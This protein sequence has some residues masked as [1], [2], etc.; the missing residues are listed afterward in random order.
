MFD[1]KTD[2]KAENVI[3]FIS[4]RHCGICVYFIIIISL[5]NGVMTIVV[6]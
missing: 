6:L 1:V 2:H 5:I 3:H 4:K